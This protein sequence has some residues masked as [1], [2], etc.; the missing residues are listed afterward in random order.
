MCPPNS[1][2]RDR[3]PR[4][5][6][7]GRSQQV[8][9][10]RRLARRVLRAPANDVGR[11]LVQGVTSVGSEVWA[12]LMAPIDAAAI[13]A[14][15][16]PAELVEFVDSAR[17]LHQTVSR[18]A[19]EVVA[20]AGLTCRP[21]TAAFYLYPDFAAAARTAGRARYHDERRP[22]RAHAGP[23]RRRRAS[24]RRIRRRHGPHGP[25]GNQSPLR[26]NRERAVGGAIRRVRGGGTATRA[27]RVAD[28]RRRADG[29]RRLSMPVARRG[30]PD[31]C[32]G[33]A[34]AA[35]TRCLN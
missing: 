32:V 6:R 4:R 29:T 33:P 19:F 16:E 3:R 7:D 10:A 15:D 20:A 5:R 8:A 23:V 12:C 35:A 18:A 24:R 2:V 9:R 31:W 26:Q 28:P 22:S 34:A 21:P 1:S 30:P 13:V 17:V 27:F 11:R 25:D 14:F